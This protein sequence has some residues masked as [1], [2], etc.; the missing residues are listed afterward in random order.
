VSKRDYRSLKRSLIHRERL[1][2]EP[3]GPGDFPQLRQL[4]IVI[5]SQVITLLGEQFLVGGRWPDSP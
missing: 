1:P 2:P 4:Q 5:L 3:P